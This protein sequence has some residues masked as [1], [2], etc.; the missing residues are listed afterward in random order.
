MKSTLNPLMGIQP[1]LNSIGHHPRHGWQLKITLGLTTT[2]LLFLLSGCTSSAIGDLTVPEGARAGEIHGLTDCEYQPNGSKEE[3]SAQ[4]GSLIVPERWNVSDSPLMALP[5]VRIPAKNQTLS[6]PVFFLQGGPGQSN[7]SFEPPDWLYADQDVVFVGYRGIDGSVVLSCPNVYRGLKKY[8][9]KDLFNSQAVRENTTAV[10]K[11]AA[12]HVKAGVDLQGYTIPNVIEDMEAARTALGYDE[13]NLLSESY[14]TRVAQIYAAMHP[15]SLHRMVL[16]GVNT[17]GRFVWNRTEIDGLINYISDLC[18]HDP[19]CNNRTD[20]LAQTVRDV[21]RTMPKRW[22]FFKIDPDTVRLGTNFL[23]LNSRDMA[24]VFDSYLAAEHGDASGLAMINLLTSLSPINQ[25]IL[26]DLIN[27]AGSVDLENYR[28][29]DS[30]SLGNSIMGAPMAEWIW[31]LA[32]EWPLDLIS[33]NLRGFQESNVEMLLVNGTIDFSTPPQALDEVIPYYHKAQTV[34]LPEF[35]HVYDVMDLQPEA[36]RKLII[37]YYTTGVGDVSGFVYQTLSF[38]PAM[39]LPTMAKILVTVVGLV[40]ALLFL[41]IVF[42][43]RRVFRH[44]PFNQLS[45]QQPTNLGTGITVS[46]NQ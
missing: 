28:G 10:K 18:A 22:L 5:I 29:I 26:G 36:F 19:A 14:G 24:M 6:Q 9:G 30:I 46:E 3:Y 23:F 32:A 4:C 1:S 37:S 42:V 35:G 11:C 41:G 33:P 2:L 20:D 13:I 25:Q 8:I 38:E 45:G 39:N 12:D 40:S 43:L 16:I 44:R 27:K 31:P 15:A 17:P 34:L 7:L 21:N